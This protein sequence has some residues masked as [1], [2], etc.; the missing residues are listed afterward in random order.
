MRSA[1]IIMIDSGPRG[2]EAYPVRPEL[3]RRGML[4][5][6]VKNEIGI[7]EIA[8]IWDVRDYQDGQPIITEDITEEIKSEA[9]SMIER[10]PE[11]ID[12]ASIVADHRRDLV[13]NYEPAE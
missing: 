2:L 11:D 8:W 7:D 1:F 10:E 12:R 3:T 4:D 9:Q 6:I 5:L 13:K